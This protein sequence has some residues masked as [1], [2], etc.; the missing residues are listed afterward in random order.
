MSARAG[1]FEDGESERVG[2]VEVAFVEQR[3]H[4]FPDRAVLV[5]NHRQRDVPLDR[6]RHAKGEDD[7]DGIHEDTA[8]SEETNNRIKDVHL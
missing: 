8:R 4:L 5:G 1:S 2:L 6:N 3:L 7:Q